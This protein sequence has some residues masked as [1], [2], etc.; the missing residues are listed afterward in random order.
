ML[1][2]GASSISMR[3]LGSSGTRTSAWLARSRLWC[4]DNTATSQV[5]GRNSNHR[6]ARRTRGRLCR[7]KLFY[8]HFGLEIH[9]QAA[10][11]HLPTQLEF[12][13]G[14]EHSIDAGNPDRGSME[15]ARAE[16]LER[17]VAH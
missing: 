8:Q 12:L 15:R 11:D 4:A 3:R 1:A 17:H 16:F 5:N 2:C 7:S 13:A 10:P 6:Y 14:I 9:P